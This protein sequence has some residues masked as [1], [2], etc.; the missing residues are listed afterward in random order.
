MIWIY[1]IIVWFFARDLRNLRLAI[2]SSC[3]QNSWSLRRNY[4]QYFEVDGASTH[5]EWFRGSWRSQEKIGKDVGI[6]DEKI[7]N[8]ELPNFPAS[9]FGEVGFLSCGVTINFPILP[10]KPSSKIHRFLLFLLV[11]AHLSLPGWTR[12][13]IEKAGVSPS[14]RPTGRYAYRA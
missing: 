3:D 12:I 2:V 8:G 13:R 11:N 9:E 10:T 5:F 14:L 4:G 1:D 7:A 6:F